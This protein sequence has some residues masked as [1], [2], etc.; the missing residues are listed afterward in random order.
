MERKK[1]MSADLDLEIERN[2]FAF[3]PQIPRLLENHAGEYAVLRNQA[4]V[5][6]QPRLADA[7]AIGD[8]KFPD[9]IY[10]IQEVTDKPV[11]LGF[12]SYADH[13]G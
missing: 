9:G 11:E 5:C 2:L 10:S 6:I 1:A 3:L 13:Q 7:M 8:L 12:F 4:V